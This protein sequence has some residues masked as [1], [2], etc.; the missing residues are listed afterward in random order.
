[1]H[2]NTGH[3]FLVGVNTC[4][5]QGDEHHPWQQRDDGH[6]MCGDE[7]DEHHPWQQCYGG[8]GMRG[9]EHGEHGDEHG[10]EHHQKLLQP[11]GC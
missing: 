3:N 10:D 2:G 6:G 5:E 11:Y 4:D 9:D 7:H 8:H 1:M